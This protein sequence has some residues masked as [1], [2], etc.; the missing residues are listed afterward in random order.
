MD[1]FKMADAP[2][3]SWQTETPERKQWTHEATGY[4]CLMVR[5]AVGAWCGYVGVWSDHPVRGMGYDELN[6]RYP[7]LPSHGE[8]T[9]AG[10]RNF[11]RPQ[12]DERPIWWVGFDCSHAFDLCPAYPELSVGSVS[13]YRTEE[14]VTDLVDAL[15]VALG[16]IP[17]EKK[18]SLNLDREVTTEDLLGD[19]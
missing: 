19:L 7:N 2:A 3:G 1:R 4:P 16:E 12:N 14:Y 13:E 10:G 11:D 6:E 15:A 17:A 18:E 8:L 5:N 9:Y